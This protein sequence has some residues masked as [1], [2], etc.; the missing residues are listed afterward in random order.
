MT[1]LCFYCVVDEFCDLSAM[2]SCSD[3]HVSKSNKRFGLG[4]GQLAEPLVPD[5]ETE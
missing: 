3:A 2:K 1:I 4:V 5:E